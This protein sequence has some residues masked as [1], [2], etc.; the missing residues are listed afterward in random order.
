MIQ[1]DPQIQ[2]QLSGTHIPTDGSQIAPG[3]PDPVQPYGVFLS[4]SSPSARIF[5]VNG[6]A[7]AVFEAFY[8]RPYVPGSTNFCLSFDL[9]T[10]A[11]APLRAQVI[12]T[13]HIV[14]VNGWKYNLSMQINYAQDGW[15]QI[16]NQAG[17][18]TNVPT[19]LFKPLPANV[20]QHYDLIS[21]INLATH[22]YSFQEIWIAGAKCTV[23]AAMQNLE[24][25][26]T[27]W[28][29]QVLV[30]LQLALN[31]TGGSFEVEVDNARV[32]SS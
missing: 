7:Y 10:D 22:M 24:A 6:P 21:S 30:Q 12:E 27:T 14:V 29:N 15:A 1:I 19:G 8:T 5:R 20:T 16:P 32:I 4:P 3:A 17:V 11:N 23:P 2:M 25:V 26:A 18:W 28:P 13:D 9:K 31:S